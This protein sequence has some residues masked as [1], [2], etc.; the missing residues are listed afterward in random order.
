MTNM[1]RIV[2]VIVMSFL[3]VQA[4]SARTPDSVYVNYDCLD[5]IYD[6]ATAHTYNRFVFSNN[7]NI[8]KASEP[9]GDFAASLQ[10]SLTEII[11]ASQSRLNHSWRANT[12]RVFAYDELEF[13][14][15]FDSLLPGNRI[16]DYVFFAP[17]RCIVLEEGRYTY[18][19][20]DVDMDFPVCE[21]HNWIQYSF[22]SL[23][24]AVLLEGDRYTGGGEMEM[25]LRSIRSIIVP[26]KG[27]RYFCDGG[28]VTMQPDTI[29]PDYRDYLWS[30]QYILDVDTL[31]VGGKYGLYTLTG[32]EVIPPV[33]DSLKQDEMYVRA[34]AGDRVILY[35]YQGNVFRDNIKRAFE[36]AYSYR[37]LDDDNR[38]YWL[39]RYGNERET[40]NYSMIGT[41]DMLYSESLSFDV[42]ITP[43]AE[44]KKLRRNYHWVGL[45]WLI[46][47]KE[48]LIDKSRFMLDLGTE[49]ETALRGFLGLSV[50]CDYDLIESSGLLDYL[51]DLDR[52]DAE[53]LSGFY[54]YNS[55]HISHIERLF[56]YDIDEVYEIPRKYKDPVLVNGKNEYS[57]WWRNPLR[58]SYIIARYK[59]K[60]GMIDACD[61]DAPVLPFEYDRIE[62]NGSYL[63]LHKKGLKCYYP[64]CAEPR[65][66]ELGPWGDFMRFTLPDGRRGWLLQ[67]GEE[68]PDNE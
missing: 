65:Y 27:G 25:S 7:T 1:K 35:D 13:N 29:G 22:D 68:F 50:R 42:V 30:R 23:N 9:E 59:G 14:V 4:L 24:I 37:V 32:R 34:F 17:D 41:D 57:A 5:F 47:D 58:S 46:D 64:A 6:T 21:T 44:K 43:P 63:T 54:L 51:G 52:R 40:F 60:Y 2:T 16:S 56:Y 49:D 36:Y 48:R 55:W 20:G 8:S 45:K 39:D 61:P 38:V 3:C 31:G 66:T 26:L 28:A 11:P 12:Q 10:G 33:Y 62:A 53:R 18:R 67:N 19:N 15:D